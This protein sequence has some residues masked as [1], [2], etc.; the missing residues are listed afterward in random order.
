MITDIDPITGKEKV[1]KT[2]SWADTGGGMW[3]DSFKK[4]NLEGAQKAIDSGVGAWKKGDETL[5]KYMEEIFE[6]MK[7]QKGGFYGERGT[8]KM[9][10]NELLNEALKKKAL[11][12]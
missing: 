1:I 11:N 12:K 9:Q 4:Q 8:C 5:D 6:E 2:F 3:E 7:G 10:A